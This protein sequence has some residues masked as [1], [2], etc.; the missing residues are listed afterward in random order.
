LYTVPGEAMENPPAEMRG[1]LG[2]KE[3]SF[4]A[5]SRSYLNR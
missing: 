4:G 1:E 3:P 5:W 2:M